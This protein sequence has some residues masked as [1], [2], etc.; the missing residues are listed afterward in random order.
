MEDEL[1]CGVG[2]RSIG[3]SSHPA[4]VKWYSMLYR[5][6]NLSCQEK[7]P[8]YVGCSVHPLWHGAESFL[9]WYDSYPYKEADWHLDKDILISGN[10]VYGPETCCIVPRE[11]NNFF[12]KRHR[13]TSEVALGVGIKR[14]DDY[15]VDYY[16]T[17]DISNSPRCYDFFESIDEAADFYWE[18]RQ[19]LLARLLIKWGGLLD[20]RVCS[21][22]VEESKKSR[23]DPRLKREPSNSPAFR[24]VACNTKMGSSSL[25]YKINGDYEDLCADC[26]L[27]V[28]EMNHPNTLVESS[29]VAI[30][31]H[32]MGGLTPPKK[33]NY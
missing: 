8:T 6:Y 14:D 19:R 31:N 26:R 18:G 16:I 12:K 30:E 17:C 5:C 4:Y 22:L 23:P 20:P 15:G 24:C 33:I 29:G 25:V 11:I 2:S 32:F 28:R 1:I 13:D 10:K 3:L 7:N 21:I 27:V 9:G